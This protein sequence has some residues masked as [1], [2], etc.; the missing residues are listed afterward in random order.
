MSFLMF[1][2]V[3]DFE[4][5]INTKNFK[6][7]NFEPSVQVSEGAASYS[8]EEDDSDCSCDRFIRTS[9]S[10]CGTLGASKLTA[11]FEED[12]DPLSN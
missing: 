4:D 7:A 5:S 1:N 12:E 6:L 3:S 2:D 8:N 10:C 9:S 11:P